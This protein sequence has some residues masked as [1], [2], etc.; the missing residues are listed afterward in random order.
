ML[1]RISAYAKCFE[2]PERWAIA[3]A[4]A[5]S[6]SSPA[7]VGTSM[8]V[9]EDMEIIG[10]LSAGC[11]E[12]AVA[13]LAQESITSG[14]PVREVFTPD[15]E[16]L[17]SV[18]LTCGGT[19]EVII[20]P[21]SSMEDLGELKAL[22]AT[23]PRTAVSLTHHI[24]ALNIALQLER[25]AAPSLILSGVHDYSVALAQLAVTAGWRVSMMDLRQDFATHERTPEGVDLYVGHPPFVVKDLLSL[26]TA[27]PFTAV[28]VMTHHPDLDVPVL[29]EALRAPAGKVDFIGAMGSWRAATKR[30]SAL[31]AKGH[32]PAARGRICSPLGLDIQASTPAETAVSMFAEII[33]TKNN[34]GPAA[35]EPLRAA[36]TGPLHRRSPHADSIVLELAANP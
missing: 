22:A 21:L 12:S 6:G 3:T 1:D 14:E 8:A 7:P 33:S 10:S 2:N 20:E 13:V 28:C 34:A 23:D 29:D 25:Q 19:L 31:A 27:E 18:A 36:K 24:S 15:G 5:V 17:G 4:T 35:G 9:S 16:R 11:A 26:E 30:G 32:S